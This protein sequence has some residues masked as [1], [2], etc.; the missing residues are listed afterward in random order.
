MKHVRAAL[1]GFGGMGSKY[2]EMIRKGNVEGL[3]LAGICCRN[4]KGQETIK[5]NYP[6]I[7]IYQDSDDMFRHRADYDALIIVTPHDTHVP[8]GL[9]A[10]GYGLHVL[11]DK[12]L[13]ISTS[14]ART[15]CTAANTAG[16][17]L[18]TIFNTRGN[19]GYRALKELID[20]GEL[21]KLSRTVW[22]CNTFFRTPAYHN[23]ADWRSTWSGEH[24]GLLVNQCQHFLDIWQWIF[25]MPDSV[26]AY[27]EYGKFTGIEVDDSFDLRLSYKSGLRGS[28]ISSSGENPGINRLE[29]WGTK[30]RLTV[31]N[32]NLVVFAEN[33]VSTGEF[34]ETNTDVYGKLEYQNREVVLPP[35]KEH[36]S[37]IFQGFADSILGKGTMI[38]DGQDGLNTLTLANAAYLS[39]WLGKSV[40]LPMDDELY[41]AMLEE[42]IRGLKKST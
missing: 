12:P 23:S 9:E 42:K 17:K 39:S 15:L 28:F 13:G 1:I 33:I 41:A 36:Y 2:V 11:C 18:G 30:G 25:G 40:E 29:I 26:D 4:K 10:V 8:L 21:G 31:E 6:D 37:Y 35:Q 3:S 34:N 22:V 38:S 20:S 5:E 24:G 27:V 7:A 19:E 16:V 32:G 14:E